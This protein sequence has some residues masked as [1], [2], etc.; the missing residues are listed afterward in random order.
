MYSPPPNIPQARLQFN[1]T[2]LHS[3]IDSKNEKTNAIIRTKAKEYMA[4]AERIRAALDSAAASEASK[5][6]AAPPTQT[7]RT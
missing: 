6:K 4:R 2:S 1:L 7:Q 5:H 3:T